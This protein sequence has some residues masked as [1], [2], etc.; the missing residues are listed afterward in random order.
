MLKQVKVAHAIEG[1]I[2]VI[3]AALKHDDSVYQGIY[4][5]LSGIGEISDFKINRVTGSITINYEPGKIEK[6]SFLEQLTAGAIEKYNRGRQ[7]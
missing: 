6:G 3:Y 5:C 1:R 7:I 2:R 4:D